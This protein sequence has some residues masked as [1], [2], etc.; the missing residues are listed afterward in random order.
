MIGR[1]VE[2]EDVRLGRKGPGKGGAAAL[3][4][5]KPRGL[6]LAGEP[7][8]FEQIARAMR[9]VAR[10]EVRF[11]EGGGGRETGEVGFLR[12]VADGDRGLEEACACIEGD[13]AGGDLQERRLA[14]AIAADKAQ[15]FATADRQLGAFEQRSAPEGQMDVLEE[16]E[17]RQNVADPHFDLQRSNGCAG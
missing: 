11:D 13:H 14:R 9:V 8:G 10:P 16:K 7:E 12:Q 6:L 2:E 1:L 15:A 4:A 5:G 17:W 3:A